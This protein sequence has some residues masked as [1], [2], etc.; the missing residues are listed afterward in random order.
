MLHVSQPLSEPASTLDVGCY[1]DCLEIALT[2]AYAMNSARDNI[3][4]R[5]ILDTIMYLFA[6]PTLQ[7]HILTRDNVNAIFNGVQVDFL[8]QRS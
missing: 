5:R 1:I 8:S 7:L 6:P 3:D 2:I 4:P